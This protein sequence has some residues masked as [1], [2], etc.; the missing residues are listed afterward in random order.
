[1]R[2]IIATALALSGVASTAGPADAGTTSICGGRFAYRAHVQDLG[3]QPWVCGGQWSGTQGLAKNLEAIE[4][5]VNPANAET[6][7]AR[8]HRSSYGWDSTFQCK[9]SGIFQIGTTGMNSP[10]EAIEVAPQINIIT[11]NAYSRNVGWLGG[12]TYAGK[13]GMI[14]TVGQNRPMEMFWLSINYVE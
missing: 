12:M 11:G 8:A 9:N 7:C 3:W 10:I 13:I 1:M 5:Q 14:G 2:V 4:F 6:F